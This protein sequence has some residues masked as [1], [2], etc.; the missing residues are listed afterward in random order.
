R[1][2]QL[3]LIPTVGKSTRTHD[4]HVQD[5]GLTLYSDM[6]GAEPVFP[7]GFAPT[8][9]FVTLAGALAFGQ[10]KQQKA[11]HVSSRCWRLAQVYRNHATCPRQQRRTIPGSR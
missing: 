2:N 7:I 3:Q 10:R 8:V 4:G 9:V 6:P 5:A 1:Q 11:A